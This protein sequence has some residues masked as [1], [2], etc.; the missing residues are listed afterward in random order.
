MNDMTVIAWMDDWQMSAHLAKL[1]STY[2]YQLKF[3][4][5]GEG[6]Y[7]SKTNKVIIIE[8]DKMEDNRLKYIQKFHQMGMQLHHAH[9]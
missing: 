7:D 1:S 3:S 2:S 6:Y 9:H 5:N 8:L 4:D